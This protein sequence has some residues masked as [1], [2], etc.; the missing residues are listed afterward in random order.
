MF[1]FCK[2]SHID[3]DF[4][5][6]REE[7]YHNA[8]PQ[9]AA[10]FVPAWF[11]NLPKGKFSDDPNAP[12]KLK[13]TIKS[14]PAFSTLYSS[15]FIFTLWSD[16]NIEV[17]ESGYRYQFV[18]GKSTIQPHAPHQMEGSSFLGTHIH[19]KLR[20]PW[21]FK[22]NQRV[23]VMFTAPTWNNFGY[24]NFVIAPGI[25]SAH[26]QP[27]EANINLFIKASS[28]RVIHQLYFGQPLAHVVPLTDKSIKLHYHLVTEKEM[29]KLYA[30][31]PLFLME[32]SRYRRAQKLCPH[33]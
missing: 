7:I 6:V 30:K 4:F 5:T 20:N 31:S 15:G 10:A 1:W 24:E 27:V 9:K 33:A 29:Q 22:T 17:T 13:S 23:N 21:A 11:K 32:G 8:K 28:Q 14:C 16:L 12:L 2:P 26:T 3:V 25:F 19:A 18:D